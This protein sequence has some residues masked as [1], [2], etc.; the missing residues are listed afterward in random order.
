MRRGLGAG[1]GGG[2]DKG[3]TPGEYLCLQAWWRPTGAVRA[4]GGHPADALEPG[5]RVRDRFRDGSAPQSRR[6]R[7]GHVRPMKSVMHVGSHRHP[8]R[9]LRPRLNPGVEDHGRLGPTQ[10]RPRPGDLDARV[11]QLAHLVCPCGLI[12][13]YAPL[14]P[15]SAAP[16]IHSARSR[17]STYWRGRDRGP[18]ASTGPPR[19]IRAAPTTAGARM[20]V[21]SEDQ[22]GPHQQRALRAERGHGG[23]LAA[24][25]VLRVVGLFASSDAPSTSGASSA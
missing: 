19:A 4:L 24:Q 21:R 6:H 2:G 17:T 5:P 10:F 14:T 18:G 1:G 11:E 3:A 25:F 20:S 13:L 9:Q 16:R 15:A 12:K 7:P 23:Q 22:P 8:H